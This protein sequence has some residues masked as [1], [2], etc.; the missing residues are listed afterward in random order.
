M[1]VKSKRAFRFFKML[2]KRPELRKEKGLDP[3]TVKE[4]TKDNKGNKAYKN[5]PEKK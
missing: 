5:L 4:M 2:E 1:P 3:K